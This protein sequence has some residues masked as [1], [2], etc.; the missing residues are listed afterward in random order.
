MTRHT[1]L[2]IIS[3]DLYDRILEQRPDLE[4][5]VEF[6][7]DEPEF[8]YVLARCFLAGESLL[9]EQENNTLTQCATMASYRH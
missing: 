6:V 3:A 4:M 1:N 7:R 2:P 5:L 9:S 8:E